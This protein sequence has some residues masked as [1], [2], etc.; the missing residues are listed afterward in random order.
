MLSCITFFAHNAQ[1]QPDIMECRNMVAA[2]EIVESGEWLVPTMN[3]RLRLKKP[4]LPTWL[5]AATYA[6]R[7]ESL[8]L[9]RGM[10]G[11][12]GLLLVVGLY[13]TVREL[14]GRRRRALLSALILLTSYNVFDMGRTASWDIYCHAFIMLAL[15]PLIRALR[16]PGREWGNF[17]LAGLLVGLSFMSKGPIALYALLLPFVVAL[18]CVERPRM[19]GKWLPLGAGVLI[20]LVVGSWWY[21]DIL[22]FHPDLAV[23]VIDEETDNWTEHHVRP[24]WYY[25]TFFT[26]TGVWALLLLTAIFLPLAQQR[27]RKDG[28][29]AVPFVWMVLSLV[30]LSVFPEK[31]MRYLLPL[32]VP[33]AAV[34]GWLM[35]SWADRFARHEASRADRVCFRTNVWLLSAVF[36]AVPVVCLLM[37]ETRLPL[38]VPACTGVAVLCVGAAAGLFVAGKSWRPLLAVGSVVTF[39]VLT[40]VCLLPTIYDLLE[41]PDRRSIRQTRDIPQLRNVQFYSPAGE[42]LRME[43]VYAA[44][45]TI[46][47]LNVQDV[48][49]VVHRLPLVILTHRPAGETLPAALWLQADSVGFGLYDDNDRKRSAHSDYRIKFLYHVTLLTP[50]SSARTKAQKRA[51][52]SKH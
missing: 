15:P 44:G 33:C 34:L 35:D 6:I 25:W 30:L 23:R 24:F 18:C 11:I 9:Q 45:R 40:V 52:A 27:S 5:T 36:V 46:L 17:C 8:A 13:E 48:N 49:A 32:M 42:E 12:F 21:I 37:R 3:G 20:C 47:P 28:S 7:P 50:K 1:D 39:F 43:E 10:A 4:P 26:E 51:I 14:T 31:K 2:R 16:R 29:F 38:S 22:V 19:R 41:N